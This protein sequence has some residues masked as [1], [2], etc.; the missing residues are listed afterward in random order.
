MTAAIAKLFDYLVVLDANDR[1]P[2]TSI[3]ILRIPFVIQPHI[4]PTKHPF[5]YQA[6]LG[7]LRAGQGVKESG[8]GD[9]SP[10]GERIW[11]LIFGAFYGPTGRSGKSTSK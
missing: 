10:P 1:V 7:N 8:R 2:V 4:T 9:D 11:A 5:A 6:I 3:R